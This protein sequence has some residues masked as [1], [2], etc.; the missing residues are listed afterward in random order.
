VVEGQS[1]LDPPVPPIRRRL[2]VLL[3]AFPELPTPPLSA[4]ALSGF[5][6]PVRFPRPA[7][8]FLPV[9]S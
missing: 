8:S 1:S 5:Q 7:G 2:P 4:S 9:S 6:P 3:S